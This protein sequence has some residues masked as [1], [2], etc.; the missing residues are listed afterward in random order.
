ML[1]VR[2][3]KDIT[4]TR[5][6]LVGQRFGKLVVVGLLGSHNN[7]HYWKCVC[8]C[9]G[10]SEVSSG[11]LRVGNSKSCGCEAKTALKRLA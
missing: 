11:S 1:N 7:K 2:T 6:N 5:F 8:D 3:Y 10:Y 4:K 9:G